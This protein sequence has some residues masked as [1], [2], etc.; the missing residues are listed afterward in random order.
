MRAKEK[1]KE[2]FDIWVP[3]DCVYV[4]MCVMSDVVCVSESEPLPPVP[5]PCSCSLFTIQIGFATRDVSGRDSFLRFFPWH[6][7]RG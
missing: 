3:D 5:V 4:C 7:T 1:R 6:K 2:G